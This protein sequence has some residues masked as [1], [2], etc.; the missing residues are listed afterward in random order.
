MVIGCRILGWLKKK[1]ETIKA[2]GEYTIIG[3]EDHRGGPGGP[4]HET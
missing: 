1:S 3:K 4:G 2:L